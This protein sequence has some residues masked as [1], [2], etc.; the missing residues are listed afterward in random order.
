MATVIALSKVKI[1]LSIANTI[2]FLNMNQQRE[3]DRTFNNQGDR[4]FNNQ[5]DRTFKSQNDRNIKV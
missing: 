4:T 5:G 2:A 3:S 1:A